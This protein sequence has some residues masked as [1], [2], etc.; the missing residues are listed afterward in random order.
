MGHWF[1]VSSESQGKHE[2]KLETSDL[3][4]Y[5]ELTDYAIEVF[6]FRPTF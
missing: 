2:I 6:L 5:S 3:Q 1:K 4:G